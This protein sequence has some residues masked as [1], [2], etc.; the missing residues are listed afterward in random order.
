VLRDEEH[1]A[2][3]VVGA[4]GGTLPELAVVHE[5]DRTHAVETDHA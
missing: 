3:V 2:A 5:G 1:D 4:D